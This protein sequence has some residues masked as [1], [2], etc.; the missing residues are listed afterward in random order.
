MN[1]NYSGN[2]SIAVV[3]SI[4]TILPNFIAKASDA[5]KNYITMSPYF[6]V[7][8]GVGYNC[9]NWTTTVAYGQ[10]A[11]I[12]GSGNYIGDFPAT[13]AVV[14]SGSFS[15]VWRQY[16]INCQALLL[17]KMTRNKQ[18]LLISLVVMLLGIVAAV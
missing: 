16:F 2:G 13:I 4:S 12:T 11:R 10:Q 8:A 3:G 17:V 5:Q 15:S 18:L 6:W 1:R 14:C 9:T 7:D